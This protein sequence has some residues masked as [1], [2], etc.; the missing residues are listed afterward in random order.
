MTDHL[1]LLI[2]RGSSDRL[3][4]QAAFFYHYAQLAEL[5]GEMAP[6]GLLEEFG[7]I[8][9]KPTI[10]PINLTLSYQ[11][12]YNPKE[13][14]TALWVDCAF[15]HNVDLIFANSYNGKHTGR[16]INVYTS[17]GGPGKLLA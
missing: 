1:Y 15:S 14:S 5:E 10:A 2:C 11:I 7:R 16:F 9:T 6:L 13:E 3:F 4:Q 17:D 8:E 12:L